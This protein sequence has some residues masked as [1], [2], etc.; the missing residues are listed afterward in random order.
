MIDLHLINMALASLGI[1]AGAVAVLA[2]RRHRDRG[3]QR[4]MSL[5]LQAGTS[6]DC[7]AAAVS[8]SQPADASLARRAACQ[9]RS[10]CGSDQP[11]ADISESAGRGSR[12]AGSH[13]VSA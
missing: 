1:G 8:P 3:A 4:S 2:A 9:A 11:A 6:V 7:D 12:P 13:V 10:A 5:A